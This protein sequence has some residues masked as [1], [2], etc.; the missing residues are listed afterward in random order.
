MNSRLSWLPAVVGIAAITG[1]ATTWTRPP[2]VAL[3]PP[4]GCR[5]PS[6]TPFPAYGTERVPPL[7]PVAVTK[8]GPAYPSDAREAGVDGTVTVAALVC[9]H[10][11]VVDARVVD[12]IPMLDPAAVEAVRQWEFR[13]PLVHG[14][15]VAAWTTIPVKFSLH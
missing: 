9:E 13:P 15:P 2:D 8:I 1:C 11:R 12:S 7:V 3:A 5:E 4:G 10:G 14:K 6:H